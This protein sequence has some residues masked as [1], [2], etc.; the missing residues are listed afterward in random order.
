[1]VD[2]VTPAGRRRRRSDAADQVRHLKALGIGLK[3][4]VVVNK[5]DRP[6]ARAA[7]VLDEVFDLFA[8]LDANDEQLDFPVLY[9]AAAAAMRARPEARATR[10]LRPLFEPIVSHVRARRR[11]TAEAVPFLGTLLDATISSAAS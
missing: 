4:I 7:E 10:A 8:A 5:I 6:D 2:G 11:W 1:M 3:P 9:G